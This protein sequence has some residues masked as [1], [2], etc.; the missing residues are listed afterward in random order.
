MKPTPQAKPQT[1]DA[2]VV[3]SGI[4]GG[5]AAKELAERGLSTLVLERGRYVEHAKDYTTEHT[6]AWEFHFRGH[7]DRK[8]Y[9]AEYSVQSQCYAFGEATRQFFVNDKENPYQHDADKPFSWI[10][11]YHLGGRSLMWGRQCYRWSDLDFEANA[12]DGFGVDWPI[13]Y[14]DIAPWYDYV[15]TFVGISGQTERIPQL[16][17]GKFLPPMEMNCA[18]RAVKE[19]IDKNFPDRIMTIGRV[20]VLTREH[21]GR[22]ECHF[23]GP[24]ER[25]CSTGSY[26]C[27]LSATLPAAQAT[28]KLTIRANS[29]VHS[30]IYDEKK[31]KAVGVR[32]IDTKTNKSLEFYGRVI[33]LCA[34]TLGSTQILLHS[35]TPRFSNGLANSSG[36]LG[37]YLMDH[38]YQIGAYGEMPGFEHEYYHGYRPNGIYIARFR[39]VKDQHPDYVRGFAYQGGAL[40]TGWER[41]V[42]TPG[43]GV[44]F[45]RAL[46]EPG[47][48]RMRLSGFGECLPRYENYVELDRSKTDKW[49]IPQLKIHC[50]WGENEKKMRGDIAGCAAEM[51]EAAGVKNVETFNNTDAPPG[52]CIHELG[53][54]RMGREPKTSVLNAYCQAHDVPNLFVTDGAAMASSACQNPSITYMAL[55]ARA[56]DYAV[57]EMK[58]GNL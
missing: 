1:Y 32:V 11:G 4:T 14:Q 35:S 9:E 3:G 6:P 47:P 52:L 36:A 40:R 56:C 2:I 23:C 34:S 5:W 31:D 39:N 37:H 22:A 48:W 26:F 24:C 57:K 54:A 19:H 29:I 28:G 18:E 58:R 55:T 46:R 10:R 20:A 25:G 7:G 30:V 21:N 41:G 33:F 13:R 15:E 12:R 49:G 17:D 51:L 43:L 16:P 27:S 45:K 44:E 38:T 8:L 53:T 42:S 50:T